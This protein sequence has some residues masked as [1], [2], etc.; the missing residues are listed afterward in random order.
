MGTNGGAVDHLDIAL[1]R[2]GNS[3]HQPAPRASFSPSHEAIVAGGARAISL[4]QVAPRCARSQHPE[5]AVQYTAVVDTWHASRLAGQ[6]RLDHTPLEVGQI[7]STHAD[8]E[9]DHDAL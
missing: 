1:V 6:E 5:D 9:S 7:V 4:R 3:V 2:G 8:A